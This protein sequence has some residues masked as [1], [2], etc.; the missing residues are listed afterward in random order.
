MA[1]G[2]IARSRCS[3]PAQVDWTSND[4]VACWSFA[5][6]DATVQERDRSYPRGAF[7]ACLLRS[8]FQGVPQDRTGGNLLVPELRGKW[9][10]ISRPP[11]I[12]ACRQRE[13][14][15]TNALVSWHEPWLYVAAMLVSGSWESRLRATKILNVLLAGLRSSPGVFASFGMH[16]SRSHICITIISHPSP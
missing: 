10:R 14:S 13:A 8:G 11:T 2:L 16:A 5:T 9:R 1:R 3:C 12:L 7:A 4:I 6:S 15:F